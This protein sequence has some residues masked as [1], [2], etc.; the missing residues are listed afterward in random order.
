M[1]TNKNGLQDLL[2]TVPKTIVPK[3]LPKTVETKVFSNAYTKLT[4]L[5]SPDPELELGQW[6]SENIEMVNRAYSENRNLLFRGFKPLD[7]K[8]EF[9][10]IV[11]QVS[12]SELLDYTEPST[13]RTQV[14]NKVYTSTEFPEEETIVQHNEHSYS[15]HWPLRIFFYCDTPSAEGGQTP[16]CDSRSVY[17]LLSPATR[18]E[19]ED[20]KVMYMRNFSDELDISWTHFFQ[21]EEKE[22][23]A[24]YCSRKNIELEWKSDDELRTR[25]VSQ[26]VM[27]HPET[28]E[29]VWFNQAHLFHYTNLRPEIAEYLLESYGEENL[30]RNA[31]YGDGG[32]IA[33]YTLNEIK[34]AYNEAMIEFEW[35]KGDFIMLDNMLY[36][37]GRKPYKGKRS[38]L[39]AMT[40]EYPPVAAIDQRAVNHSRKDTANYFLEQL[41]G[42][43]DETSIKYKLAVANRMM[44][45]LQ[46]EEG[47]IS[48]HISVKVPGREDAFWV[49][50]FGILSEEVTPDN[51]VMVDLDG[52]VLSGNHPVNVAGFCIHAT[53]HK[54]NPD[55]HCIVHT[56]SPWGTVFSCLDKEI[57]PLD[58]NCCMFFENH[59]LFKEFSGP[60]N[61][62]ADA[63]KLAA[64]LQGKNAAVLANHGAITC[65]EDIETAIMYMVSMER[66]FRLNILAMQ[67]GS[68]KQVDEDVA[69]M[70]KDWIANPIGF[71]IEFAAL[72]RKV[73]RMYPE[74]LSYKNR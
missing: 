10:S 49:N 29:K 27:V 42:E 30:P 48:G 38:I 44:A 41:G 52:R 50:P 60:V 11:K 4:V 2:N 68:Y 12:G 54:A 37:H 51:L 14:A 62:A 5:E 69:R 9:P 72:Q 21:T 59:T 17:K 19:F 67:S 56:H 46:L 55:V 70:T 24:A 25:Q 32:R 35:K 63:K 73:E 58:Q 31:Y 45:A 57:L 7:G 22:A 1:G 23:V 8:Q 34:A 18:K 13:P 3:A 33:D 16:I 26:S 74:L 15:N 40:D 39:V 47:G 61:D 71:R 28:G 43:E 65:G 66:A 20:K 53:I 36:T 6:I 64:A